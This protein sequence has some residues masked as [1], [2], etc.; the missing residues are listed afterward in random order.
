M[1]NNHLGFI[2]FASG[3][4]G[5]RQQFGQFLRAFHA[6]HSDDLVIFLQ[7]AIAARQGHYTATDNGRDHAMLSQ[8]QIFKFNTNHLCF[9]RHFL[10]HH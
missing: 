7:R 4:N 2:V 1:E 10:F 8:S 6:C 5:M 9:G 3:V